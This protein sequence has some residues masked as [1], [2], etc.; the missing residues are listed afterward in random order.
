VKELDQRVASPDVA[1]ACGDVSKRSKNG[2]LLGF[3]MLLPRHLEIIFEV[4]RR[5]L[6]TV[7]DRFPADEERISRVSLIEE[8]AERKIRMAHLAI[9]GSHSTNGSR[10]FIPRCCVR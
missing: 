1:A 4:N 3:E 8:G 9:V 2:R 7:R 10:R 5:L 6:D